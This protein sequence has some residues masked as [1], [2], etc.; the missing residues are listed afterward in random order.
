M[1]RPCNVDSRQTA[2]ALSLRYEC[3]PPPQLPNQWPLGI[4]WIK[5]LWQSDSEQ[6]LLAFLCSIA[7]GYEPRNNLFQHLLFGPRAF[8]IL[9]PKN[10]EAV[11]SIDFQDKS[12]QCTMSFSHSMSWHIRILVGSLNLYPKTRTLPRYK[13]DNAD[14][15]IMQTTASEI[16][17]VSSRLSWVMAS[18]LKRG[19]RGSTPGNCCASN[20]FECNIRIWTYFANTSTT[21]SRS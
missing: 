1:P 17:T 15:F 6:H 7:D 12:L 21:F 20:S 11:L 9:D 19:R 3:L 5:K 10:L 16:A 4:D 2:S 13:I 8:H 14:V 18:S